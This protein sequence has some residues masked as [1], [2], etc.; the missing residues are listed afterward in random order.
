MTQTFEIL[1]LF[2]VKNLLKNLG[3]TKVKRFLVLLFYLSQTCELALIQTVRLR[4]FVQLICF[5]FILQERISR[6]EK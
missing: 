6:V 5:I 1:A 4:I 3:R 2:S